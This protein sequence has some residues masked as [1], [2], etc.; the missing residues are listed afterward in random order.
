VVQIYGSQFG[1]ATATGAITN[2]QL[3]EALGG[4]SVSI[5]GLDAPLYYSSSGQIN[6]LVPTELA[7]NQQ[8]EVIAK[9]NG[10][11]SA[12]ELI[13][14]V[15]A[16]PGIAVYGDGSAIAQDAKFNLI[17]ANH[18][19]H[20]GDTIILYLTGMG[21]TTPAVASGAPAPSSPLAQVAIQP[22]VTVDGAQA[23]VEFAGLTPGAVGLYQVD[24]RIPA[25][26]RTGNLAV[27]VT[28][29]SAS[30]NTATVPVQ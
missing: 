14:T 25:A 18:P 8:Y 9:V 24:V 16:Q 22:Q 11:Y 21:A 29:G 28:Q 7:A 17:T 23:Q 20:A 15:P 13:N 26:A 5:G 27:I 12:P 1:T 2:G 30:S 10:V 6:A 3:T 4:V 19:A